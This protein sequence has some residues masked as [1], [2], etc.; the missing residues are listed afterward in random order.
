MEFIQGYSNIVYDSNSAIEI[1]FLEV[2]EYV[3]AVIEEMISILGDRFNDFCFIFFSTNSDGRIPAT[4]DA[5]FGGRKKV[6][7]YLL[8]E[9]G[10]TIEELS[11]HYHCI[12]KQYLPIESGNNIYP[13][14]LGYANGI[15]F[16]KSDIKST[17]E[18]GFNA[19]FSGSMNKNRTDFFNQFSSVRIPSTKTISKIIRVPLVKKL[20]RRIRRLINKYGKKELLLPNSVINFTDGFNQ[21]LPKTAYIDYLLN[22]KVAL[23]PSG[24]SCV[25]SYRLY[26]AMFAGCVVISDKLPN[27]SLY[28]E[29][30]I[31]QIDN[32]RNGVEIAQQLFKSSYEL[33]NLQRASLE[34]WESH[35]SPKAVAAYI[36]MKIVC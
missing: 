10:A 8:D 28:S 21:G 19:F 22:S 5:D 30:P 2:R 11:E 33:E 18:R 32:W 15:R 16:A 36:S 6:L 35:Y 25:E 23:C 17:R 14:P 20:K 31:I 24:A 13:F 34:Y 12:F 1:S 3:F 9:A 7:F 26:E 4:M 27:T 29:S